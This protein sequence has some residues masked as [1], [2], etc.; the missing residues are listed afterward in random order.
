MGWSEDTFEPLR[1]ASGK[2]NMARFVRCLRKHRLIG[3]RDAGVLIG[4]GVLKSSYLSRL[5]ANHTEE[6]GALLVRASLVARVARRTFGLEELRS[7]ICVATVRHFD[8]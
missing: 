3:P 1:P 2:P 6:I 4:G 5:T 8:T 7:G